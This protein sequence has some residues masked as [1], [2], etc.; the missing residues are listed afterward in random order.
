MSET[1]QEY[2]LGHKCIV[3]TDKNL[4]SHL[5]S[6][7]LS[8]TEQCCVAQLAAFDFDFK[9]RSGRSNKN[10]AITCCLIFWLCNSRILSFKRF[11]FS[12]NRNSIQTFRRGDTSPPSFFMS[13][14][15]GGCAGRRSLSADFLIWWCRR[16]LSSVAAWCVETRSYSSGLSGALASGSWQNTRIFATKMLL[17]R[18]DFWC[19]PVLQGVQ[20]CQVSKDT[21][22]AAPSF[23]EHLMAS[24]SNKNIGNW[25]YHTETRPEWVIKFCHYDW[26]VLAST[27]WSGSINSV[28]LYVF[29]LIRADISKGPWFSNYVIYLYGGEKSRTTPYHPADKAINV[30]ARGWGKLSQ[31]RFINN[32]WVLSYLMGTNFPYWLTDNAMLGIQPGELWQGKH[33]SSVALE[34]SRQSPVYKTKNFI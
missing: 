5:S 12:G 30:A 3:Y 28:Y 29:T 23:M 18:Y 11:R 15:L 9:Y 13:V 24:H 34:S 2:L 7:K 32:N 22:M 33:T 1:F 26:C 21:Q 25:F 19:G 10:A 16:S 4:L 20:G 8:A 27:P 14:V 31:L 6:A 17:A